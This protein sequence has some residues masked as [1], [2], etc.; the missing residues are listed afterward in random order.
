MPTMTVMTEPN[1]RPALLKALGIARM[2]VPSELFSRWRSAPT[3][4]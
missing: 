2:P 1:S 4:L 3:V